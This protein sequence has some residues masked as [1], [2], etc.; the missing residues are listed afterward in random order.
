MKADNSTAVDNVHSLQVA[1][2]ESAGH[3]AISSDYDGNRVRKHR[4]L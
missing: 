3:A 2:S 1:D 4:M